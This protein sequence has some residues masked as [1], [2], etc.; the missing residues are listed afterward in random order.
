MSIQP[1]DEDRA[2]YWAESTSVTTILIGIT[3]RGGSTCLL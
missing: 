2:R 3:K 1:N